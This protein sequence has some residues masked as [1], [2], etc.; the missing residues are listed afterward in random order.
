MISSKPYGMLTDGTQATLYTLKNKS[1]ASLSLCDYGARIVSIIVPDKNGTLGEVALGFTS[2]GLY[3]SIDSYVGAAIGRASNRINGAA[4]DIGDKH[5]TVTANEGTTCLHGG[6]PGFDGVMWEAACQEGEEGDVVSFRRVSPDGEQG[7]PGTLATE[8]LYAWTD[9]NELCISYHAVCDQDTVCGLT[10][11][12]YFNLDGSDT[13]KNHILCL[14]APLITE[15]DDALIPTGRELD[16][17]GLPVDM[18]KPLLLREGFA[19]SDEYPMMVKK[20]GYDFNFFVP[21]EGLRVH[22][23][24]H[25]PASGRTMHMCSTEPCVQ[26]YSGQH[27][28]TD[29]GLNGKHYGAYAGLA[30][31]TQHHP[32]AVHHENFPSMILKANE[33]YFS[34]TLYAFSAE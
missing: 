7:F 26:L 5:Y 22:A 9:K 29:G 3:E 24:L 2:A 31:E 10:N 34:Q 17:A 18:Q 23:V 6:T 25:A 21:G 14:H 27:F 8:I 32:D 20:N 15:T 13:I 30:L 4:F 16:V 1:G 11:H 12:V 28:D 19:R 33:P